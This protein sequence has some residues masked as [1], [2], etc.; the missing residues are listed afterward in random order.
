[1]DPRITSFA[2]GRGVVGGRVV[3][4]RASGCRVMR[5]SLEACCRRWRCL[6]LWSAVA[7]SEGG[8][9]E[10][11]AHGRGSGRDGRQNERTKGQTAERNAALGIF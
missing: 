7:A 3:L 11:V 2:L 8:G 10:I 6:C 9:W 5:K 1:M 4:V